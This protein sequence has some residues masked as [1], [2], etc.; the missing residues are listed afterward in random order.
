[1][2]AL[3]GGLLVPASLDTQL[4]HPQI[5]RDPFPLRC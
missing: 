4:R 1:V 2:T 5:G 3:D